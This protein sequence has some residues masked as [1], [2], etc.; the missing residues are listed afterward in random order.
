MN[1]F[2]QGLMLTELLGARSSIKKI[3]KHTKKERGESMDKKKQIP[4]D[5]N[6][7]I[8]GRTFDPS[9]YKGTSQL[10]RV[11]QLHMNKSEMIIQKER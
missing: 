4:N 11:W 3:I 2:S 6:L 7:K 8:A 1:R 10:Q 5:E 9:D